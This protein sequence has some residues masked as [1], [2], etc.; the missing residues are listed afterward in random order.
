MFTGANDISKTDRL[1]CL[2]TGLSKSGYFRPDS[3]PL[4]LLWFARLSFLSLSL[5]SSFSIATCIRCTSRTF[6]VFLSSSSQSFSPL[7]PSHSMSICSFCL[8]TFLLRLFFSSA[9]LAYLTAVNAAGP[10]Q[11]R[12]SARTEW[13]RKQE[14]KAWRGMYS[15]IEGSYAWELHATRMQLREFKCCCWL[16]WSLVNENR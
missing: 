1:D 3:F 5:F 12:P 7:L 10:Q 8:S 16:C 2:E 6:C 15:N 9:S 13:E 14:R 4:A 11:G